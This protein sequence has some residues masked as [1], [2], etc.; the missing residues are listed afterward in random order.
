VIYGAPLST[1]MPSETAT[2]TRTPSLG[3]TSTS[4]LIPTHTLTSTP[5]NTP[6]ATA[7]SS[8]T[9][10]N[11][12]PPTPT[13]TPSPT[14]TRLPPEIIAQIACDV[15]GSA[16]WCRGNESL[17]LIASDPQGFDVTISDD[18]NAA[19]F[20]CRSSCSVPLPEGVGNVSYVAT[21][22]SGRTVR[23]LSAWQRDSTPPTLNVFV[24]SIDGK[25]G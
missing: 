16:G 10:T 1:P 7:T 4:T 12:P 8:Q 19:R 20:S 18:I 17:D 6:S 9:P 3:P 25:N 24:P 15:W 14:P 22:T 5:T 13:N 11:T 21:S 23:G 2:I